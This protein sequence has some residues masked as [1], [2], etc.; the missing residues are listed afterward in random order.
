[1]V[2]E[3]C[4]CD[5]PPVIGHAVPMKSA[6]VCTAFVYKCMFIS[7]NKYIEWCSLSYKVLFGV[8]FWE[9]LPASCC[10]VSTKHIGRTGVRTHVFSTSW[11]LQKWQVRR[12]MTDFYTCAHIW[13][14]GDE[15]RTM[16]V[17]SPAGGRKITRRWSDGNWSICGHRPEIARSPDGHRQI[18]RRWP[19]DNA[20]ENWPLAASFGRS[21]SG[22][23]AVTV[24]RP[25]SQC[26]KP[27]QGQEN[28][29]EICRCRKIGILQQTAKNRVVTARFQKLVT[30]LLLK[31]VKYVSKCNLI[32]HFN[33]FVAPFTLYL[34]V[35]IANNNKNTT[36]TF[37]LEQYVFLQ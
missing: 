4:P 27:V 35:E 15:N 30:P 9:I 37:W 23:P 22:R 1:M 36:K 16:I 5:H 32:Y 19:S 25:L 12:T 8:I 14:R 21:P 26:C 17:R 18:P 34:D 33:E 11:L 3:R 13:G 31:N 24:R 20:W 29:P 2:I 28:R 10:L 7:K 6:A